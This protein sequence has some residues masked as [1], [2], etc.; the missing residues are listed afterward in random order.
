MGSVNKNYF[1]VVQQLPANTFAND[2]AYDADSAEVD[3]K[4]FRWALFTLNIGATDVTSLDVKLQASATSGSGYADVTG[5]TFT[6]IGATDDDST[7]Y[8]LVDCQK[9]A[10]YLILDYTQVG[11]TSSDAAADCVLFEPSDTASAGTP[12]STTV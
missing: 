7:Q 11:G 5:A 10:R 6:T 2:A 12:D 8:I 3:A 1:K 4:G 9:I